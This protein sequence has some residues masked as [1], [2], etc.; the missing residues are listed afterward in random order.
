MLQWLLE[1]ARAKGTPFDH[2]VEK[3]LLVNFGAIL[4]YFSNKLE[5]P[6]RENQGIR[7][8]I[9]FLVCVRDAVRYSRWDVE[10]RLS[11][12][13]HSADLVFPVSLSKH[14]PRHCF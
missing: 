7:E 4:S 6:G 2:V 9:D 1:E 8:W 12:V 11:Y 14:S 10:Q 13:I 5:I 3:V